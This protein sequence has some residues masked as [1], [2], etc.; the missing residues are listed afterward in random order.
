MLSHGKTM[1]G[2][3]KVSCGYAAIDA[4][5]AIV[6]LPSCFIATAFV[7]SFKLNHYA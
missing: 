6:S 5:F 1:M 4:I 3:N 2:K 7:K